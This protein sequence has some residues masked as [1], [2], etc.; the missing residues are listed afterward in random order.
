MKIGEKIKKAR[1]LKGWTQ[2]QL[3]SKADLPIARIQ[4]YETNFRH[5]KISQLQA[6]S[7]ALDVPI[8]YFTEF[9]LE[10]YNSIM[11]A[12]FELE[13]TFNLRIENINGK[14]MFIFDDKQLS[15]YLSAWAKEKENSS[16]SIDTLNA[17]DKWK[18]T[19]K[20]QEI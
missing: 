9:S 16:L 19:F 2:A 14:P 5:P 1:Q 4:Q 11:F 6:I 7:K 20:A 15:M 10:T 17:Y 18:M 8:E 12:L 3:A 13:D